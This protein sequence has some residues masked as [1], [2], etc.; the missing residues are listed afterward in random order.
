MTTPTLTKLPV[1]D[2]ELLLNVETLEDLDLENGAS[3]IMG[4]QTGIGRTGSCQLH[5]A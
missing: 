1:E 3:E 4:G 2:L 5:D